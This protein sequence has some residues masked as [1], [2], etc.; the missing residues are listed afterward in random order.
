MFGVKE[1][2]RTILGLTLGFLLVPSCGK[3]FMGVPADGGSPAD[4]ARD[5]FSQPDSPPAPHDDAT[6]A[7]PD[8][9]SLPDLSQ[10][11]VYATPDLAP[12]R[13]TAGD[14]IVFADLPDLASREVVSTDTVPRDANDLA[15]RPR[16][17]TSPTDA[18]PPPDV[19][20]RIDVQPSSDTVPALPDSSTNPDAQA[21]AALCTSSRGAVTTATCCASAS[22]F[23]DT[24]TTAE[25]ACGCSPSSSHTVNV[26]TCPNGGCFLP[27]QGCVGPAATCTIG[28]DQTC[29]DSP[30][31][32]S[33]HGKCVEGGRCLCTS[34]ALSAASGKCL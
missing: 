16:D 21:A 24:C 11:D 9:A 8:L 14:P 5:L 10:N 26:C 3:S 20:P 33:I 29:N 15:D 6:P 13:D 31:I 25:G 22:D 30:T 18:P 28:A 12:P 23:R 34:F 27:G 1:R 4:A 2:T 19:Q 32:S 7:E 17:T